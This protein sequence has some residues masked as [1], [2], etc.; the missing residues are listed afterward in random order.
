MIDVSKIRV[1]DEVTVRALVAESDDNE[2]YPIRLH[3]GSWI[4]REN[5]VEHHPK[6]RE[7]KPGDRVT[8]PTE[9]Y[10]YELI[11]IR[12]DRAIIWNED[13]GAISIPLSDLHH[14]DESE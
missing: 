6:P 10:E 4:K 9:G 14:A 7:F 1:G 11:A 5:V 13:Y 3:G 2:G 12:G 8:W